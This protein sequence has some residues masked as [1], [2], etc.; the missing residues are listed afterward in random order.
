VVTTADVQTFN[1]VQGSLRDAIYFINNDTA[2]N[3]YLGSHGVDE[4]DFALPWNDAGHVYY[5]GSMGNVQLVPSASSSDADLTGAAA[6]WQHS[7]WRM[8][9]QS[10][11]PVITSPVFINGYSQSGATWNDQA[12]DDDAV[13]RIELNG[14]GPKP[15]NGNGL[16]IEAPNTTVRGLVINGFHATGIAMIGS[17]AYGDRVQGNFI[18]TDI[19]GTLAPYGLPNFA[20]DPASNASDL[21]QGVQVY[22]PPSGFQ[23][24]YIGISPNDPSDPPG[25]NGLAERNIVSAATLGVALG[26]GNNITDPSTAPSVYGPAQTNNVVAGNFIG[27]DRHGTTALG[28]WAGV[29]I[30]SAHDDLVNG[31]VISGNEVGVLL[32]SDGSSG[33]NFVS[34]VG[35]YRCALTRNSIGTDVNGGALG[36]LAA[37]VGVIQNALAARIGGAS[38]GLGNTIAYNGINS[39]GLS[40]DMMYNGAP[41]ANAPGVWIFSLSGTPTGT[42]VQG[43]SIYGNAG[44]GVDLGGVYPTP[45][46][47]GVDN[48]SVPD[49][50]NTGP[51]NQQHYPQLVAVQSG[52]TTTISGSLSS[53]NPGPYTLDFYANP[54]ADP[55]GYGQGQIYLGSATVPATGNFFVVLPAAT[56]A[57]EFI[58]ATGTDANGD[59]SEFSADVA[60]TTNNALLPVLT[61]GGTVAGVATT[62]DAAAQAAIADVNGLPPSTPLSTLNLQLSGKVNTVTV[63]APPNL[64]LNINGVLTPAGTTLDPNV[65]A[66]VVNAG[67]VI[68]SHVTFTESG[69]APTILVTG[70]SLT[71]RNDIIQESTGFAD[72]AISITGGIVDLGTGPSP[73]GNVL[74]VNGG[75]RFIDNTTGNSIPQVGDTFEVNGTVVS[76]TP[77]IVTNT[78]DSGPG[79]LRDAIAQINAD[80]HRSQYTSPSDPT[81]DEIDFNI[82]GL[83]PSTP[84]TITLSGTELLV[85]NSVII[86]GP[87][88][89]L[90]AVSGNGLSRIF[91]VGPGASDTISGLT[92]EN[93]FLNGNGGGIA[94]H[95]TL[96]VSA[97]SLSGNGAGPFVF[98]GGS[99][100]AIYNNG[101]LTVSGCTM[102]GNEDGNAGSAIYNTGTL[103]LLGST[104]GALSPNLDGAEVFNF[105]GT[106]TIS[107]STLTNSRGGGGIAN[108]GG[109]VT[110]TGST[111][112]NTFDSGISNYSNGTMTVSGCTV[113]GNSVGGFG[114]GIFNRGSM[115]VSNTTISGN[116]A[117]GPG[118]IDEGGGIANWG[119][120]TLTGSTVS[121][122]SAVI[123]TALGSGAEGG[124]VYN[125]GTISVSGCALSGNSANM[126]GGVWNIGTMA[127][128]GSSVSGNSVTSDPYTGNPGESA[129]ISNFGTM[130]LSRSTL[131]GNGNPNTAFGGAI[132]NGGTLT[133]SGCSLSANSAIDGGGI[134]NGGPITLTDCILSGNAASDSGGAIF[135]SFGPM[136]L[137]GCAFSGNTAN[138]GGGIYN[139]NGPGGQ[140]ATLTLNGCSL[141]VNSANI[142]GGGI[143]NNALGMLTIDNAGATAIYGMP[144]VDI[145]S[146]VYGNQA[147]TG[148]DLENLGVL[149]ITHSAV[150][151]LDNHNSGATT[152]NVAAS[153]TATVLAVSSPTMGQV[154]FNVRVLAAKAGAATP[155]GTVTLYDGNN[156][157]LGTATLNA[158]EQANF[159]EP[160][161]LASP[162]LVHA[163]YSGAG[164]FTGSTSAPP[165]NEYDHFSGFLAPLNS[166]MAFALGRTVPIKFQ[167]T[168]FNGVII[169]QLSA[170]NALVVSGP[171]G[172]TTLTGSLRY[173]STSNQYIVNWE[174]KGLS[175]GNY[176]ITLVLADG[177]THSKAIQ[178]SK[179]GNSAGL[180]TVAAGGTGDAPGGLLGGDITLYVDNTNADLTT[181]ELARI[182][183]AVTAVDA[184]TE[185]FGVA[186]T[187]VTDP[188]LADVT[189]NMDTT[190]TV[191]GFADGVLGCTT[192][193][194]QITIIS[195]WNFYAGSDAT[196]IGSGQYDFETVVTHELGHAL[197][198]G[199]S[200]D[201]TSVMYA[202][203][204]TG[205][206]NR[207]LTTADLNVPDGDPTGA[208]G[209]HA[210]LRPQSLGGLSP[211]IGMPNVHS[212]TLSSGG[213]AL[214]EGPLA[215]AMASTNGTRPALGSNLPPFALAIGFA[216]PPADFSNGFQRM[217][218]NSTAG[219]P[220][221]RGRQGDNPT[222][223]TRAW[224]GL[225]GTD[226]ATEGCGL[227]PES[228]GR[229]A[230]DL[231]FEAAPEVIGVAGRGADDLAGRCL[232]EVETVDAVFGA[233]ARPDTAPAGLAA[234]DSCVN[235]LWSWAGA[236]AVAL[237]M[238]E[239]PASDCPKR[240]LK[241][242]SAFG[243]FRAG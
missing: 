77:Y 152:T 88:A 104:L 62:T 127:V 25:W 160:A 162:L 60:A 119:T 19:S 193:A 6:Q 132:G 21:Y 186:V 173:D 190:S 241:R 148:A 98:G 118:F 135:N 134:Q 96:T 8:Q 146:S 227:A 41:V 196:Q 7:W 1:P 176:A 75:G 110:V 111:V 237:C 74:N 14:R 243:H 99:G 208:C 169:S 189:L 108:V 200:S 15:V 52:S 220:E 42:I 116:T 120:M 26:S 207:S 64:T 231:D 78:A 54:A 107:T 113:S 174:T 156:N 55:S 182:Q 167:L 228:V 168:D 87:G 217:L 224:P 179:S 12:N 58:S 164:S 121:G 157:A 229:P 37:G 44:L 140:N 122:N 192:D 185:P 70:G 218:N 225:K 4:I 139:G 205:T 223:M 32:A 177:T 161:G 53:N 43:N 29:T 141:V 16:S 101:T 39:A 66:L 84:G 170:V 103:M 92:I 191:G 94:N 213:N 18:G 202:T 180:T 76:L 216:S 90:V 117:N 86:N 48:L 28:N 233:E 159:T 56:T 65:P 3:Q 219:V 34:S 181:D 114:G 30:G 137:S 59:T 221:G 93:G 50:P 184:V 102:D 136:T 143:Y 215:L 226:F 23:Q 123:S 45:G 197:G 236:V 130:T 239:W 91:E 230:T 195:G 188:T 9:L 126:G 183:D 31:N 57:G 158:A 129:G 240:N 212:S 82:P 69:D 172:T 144:T 5:Q 203:L 138:L 22:E 171:S 81:R 199:H 175:A 95:G 33:P 24:N 209:L 63:N 61:T 83:S 85:S 214:A 125:L 147:P 242:L 149:G 46:P 49:G 133:V 97:C 73:G 163:V 11:L 187:E 109:F 72:A 71:L 142:S 210:V 201:S 100:G 105:G 38:A 20:G 128:S 27:T 222:A 150:V 17:S 131:I 155:T 198:L 178:L 232:L 106:A 79:S 165:L 154:V 145:N 112:S 235:P 238:Q 124:G 89:G 2:G 67:N 80:T 10:A 36:N 68:V 153:D 13:L 194:G 151:S 211:S 204:G 51:N 35:S 166:S 47:D 40:L 206:V 234:G 115:T